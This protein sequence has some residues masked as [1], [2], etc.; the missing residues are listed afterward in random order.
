MQRYEQSIVVTLH[1][2]GKEPQIYLGRE[3]VSME[4]LATRLQAY[5]ADKVMSRAMVLLKTDVGIPAG[6]QS[7][8]L[9]LILQM[10]FKVAIVGKTDSE[11]PQT[12]SSDD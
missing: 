7:E 1:T 11:T 2:G 5:K 4:T 3:A 12:K 6:K 8:I 10:G 9:N